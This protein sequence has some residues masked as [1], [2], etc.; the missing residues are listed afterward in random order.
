MPINK[1]Q[2]AVFAAQYIF[3]GEMA[4]F[5]GIRDHPCVQKVSVAFAY[6]LFDIIGKQKRVQFVQEILADVAAVFV[7]GMVHVDKGSVL[8][9][10]GHAGIAPR[11]D[12]KAD[13]SRKMLRLLLEHLRKSVTFPSSVGVL[14]DLIDAV[15][16]DQDDRALAVDHAAE[17]LQQ[18]K[19]E[20]A[21]TRVRLIIGSTGP[22]LFVFQIVDDLIPVIRNLGGQ[23]KDK[24][25]ADGIYIVEV[26]VVPFAEQHGADRGVED[27]F[28]CHEG[29]LADARCAIDQKG[30]GGFR[31]LQPVGHFFGEPFSSAEIFL[32]QA[33]LLGRGQVRVQLFF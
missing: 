29:G 3:K 24:D 20:Y 27:E 30:L 13:P 32:L 15:D 11:R 16:Q 1:T 12:D 6:E 9:W 14:P 2:V 17:L 33:I 31:V 23:L 28:V 10:H 7:R 18:Q 26:R 21:V 19:A 22:L 8:K 5:Q 25:S 4:F